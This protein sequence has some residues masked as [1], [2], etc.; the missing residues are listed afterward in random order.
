MISYATQRV[1]IR[2]ALASLTPWSPLVWAH[3]GAGS[4]DGYGLN[5]NLNP[6]LLALLVTALVL[7]G[8]GLLRLWCR[9]RSG[10]AAR[11]WQVMCYGAGLLV[12]TVAL[13][14]PLDG[15]ASELAAAH[16]VQH[17]MLIAV[18]APLLVMASPLPVFL[19][20]LPASLRRQLRGAGFVWI[21]QA[22][23]FLTTPFVAWALHATALWIW[24]APA[25]Y[26]AALRDPRLHDLE[27][28][29]LFGTALL[30]WWAVLRGGG[31]RSRPAL[32]IGLLFTTT[33]HS[34]VLAALMTF[35]RE[36]WY[37]AYAPTTARWGFTPLED[38]Q[39]AGLIMW[40]PTG[41]LYL[42]ASLMLLAV[43]LTHGT[44][45]QLSPS[46]RV[47]GHVPKLVTAGSES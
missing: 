3:E 44:R 29:T 40:V 35:S 46:R 10:R 9:S 16:M 37:P 17:V 42:L 4:G 36:P 33:T 6:L 26:Q 18:A 27:H 22:W 19:W 13:I 15:M 30:F 39:L 23:T 20:A 2:L 38:Q 7:Y 24:H 8:L 41:F 14:S 45:S 34:G 31:K 28:A 43:W 12:V 21:S 47:R 5:L 1:L 32:A 25:L 11:T